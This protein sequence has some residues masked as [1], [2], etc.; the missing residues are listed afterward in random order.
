MGTT[1]TTLAITFSA[2]LLVCLTAGIVTCWR[3]SA[4][5]KQDARIEG[6]RGN[7]EAMES[8]HRRAQINGTAIPMI[9]INAPTPPPSR[10]V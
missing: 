3:M 6:R 1:G 4:Q 2:V 7:N 9:K 10:W 8:A 5:K